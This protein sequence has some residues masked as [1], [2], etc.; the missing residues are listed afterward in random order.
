MPARTRLASLTVVI[1]L[2]AGA[3]AD[4]PG[5][6]SR[7]RADQNPP[8]GTCGIVMVPSQNPSLDQSVV[9]GEIPDVRWVNLELAQAMLESAGF[10][11]VVVEDAADADRTVGDERDWYVTRQFPEPGGVRAEDAGIVLGALPYDEEGCP[12]EIQYRR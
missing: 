4:V 7:P 10:E 5:V 11:N 12:P 8:A 3:C 2:A 6:D 9:R 1:L